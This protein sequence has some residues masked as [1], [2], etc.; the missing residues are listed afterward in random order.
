VLAVGWPGSV[1]AEGPRATVAAL[2]AHEAAGAIA[3]ADAIEELTG[4]AQ[5]DG[6]TGLPNRSTWEAHLDRIASS[7]EPLT[8]AILDLDHFKEFNDTHGHPAGDRLLKET[9]AA[10]RDKL[11]IGAVLARI[12]GEEFGLLLPNCDIQTASEIVGR[13]WRS[14]T[15]QRTCSA[16]LT[17]ATPANAPRVPSP[18]PTKRSTKPKPRT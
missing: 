11:R 4:E 2:L 15:Q 16:G 10:W 12:G 14:V 1:R 17:V 5:T 8:I 6:L 3:R 9:A 13:L 7:R 18:A